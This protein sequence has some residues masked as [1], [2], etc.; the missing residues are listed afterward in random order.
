ME[1]SKVRT[2]EPEMEKGGDASPVFSLAVEM[3]LHLSE[4]SLTEISHPAFSEEENQQW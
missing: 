4:K 3:Y 2:N 1:I